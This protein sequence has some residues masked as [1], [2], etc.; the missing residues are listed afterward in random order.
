MTYTEN[1]HKL[2]VVETDV[3]VI[4]AGP[5]GVAAAYTEAHLG[6]KTVIV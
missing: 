6:A 5:A 3:L 1:A 4:G 2:P